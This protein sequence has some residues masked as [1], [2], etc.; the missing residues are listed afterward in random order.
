M[1]QP[2]FLSDMEVGH[3]TLLT[4]AWGWVGASVGDGE[5]AEQSAVLQEPSHAEAAQEL[6]GGQGQRSQWL[7]HE[8]S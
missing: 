5:G 6:W 8:G 7:E 2:L 4:G 1:L 3:W